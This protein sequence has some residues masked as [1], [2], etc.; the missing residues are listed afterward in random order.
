M[1]R[2]V[3]Q[4]DQIYNGPVYANG[5]G[6]SGGGHYEDFSDDGW[7]GTGASIIVQVQLAQAIFAPL[8]PRR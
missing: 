2:G 5:A 6:F 3:A 7:Q 1:R 4:G 8:F